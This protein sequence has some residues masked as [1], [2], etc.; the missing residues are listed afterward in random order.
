MAKD[1]SIEL[2][3]IGLSLNPSGQL[4]REGSDVEQPVRGGRHR[5]LGTHDHVPGRRGLDLQATHCPKLA[6]GLE[7]LHGLQNHQCL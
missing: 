1:D 7:Q 3:Q 2:G 6:R 5:P 4:V